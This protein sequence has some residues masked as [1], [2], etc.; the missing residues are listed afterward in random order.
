MPSSILNVDI[1]CSL[2]PNKSPGILENVDIKEAKSKLPIKK[3]FTLLLALEN[4][5]GTR[6]F[7]AA[8]FAADTTAFSASISLAFG[9]LILRGL[10]FDS[11]SNESNSGFS[12]YRLSFLPVISKYA[13]SASSTYCMCLMYS[14][15]SNADLPV[16]TNAFKSSTT[17][18]NALVLST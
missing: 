1:S 3:S 14:C 6:F 13:V 2:P 4:T 15:C 7:K 5:L 9:F 18:A 12:M 16:S 17:V 10:A 11:G 8:R